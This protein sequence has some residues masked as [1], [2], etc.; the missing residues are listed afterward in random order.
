MNFI[1]QLKLFLKEFKE[2][3]NAVYKENYQKKY[4]E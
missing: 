2:L 4:N 1:G 3:L